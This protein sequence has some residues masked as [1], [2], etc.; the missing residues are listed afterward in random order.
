VLRVFTSLFLRRLFFGTQTSFAPTLERPKFNRGQAS[1]R[2]AA[3]QLKFQR[4]MLLENLSE[5]SKTPTPQEQPTMRTRILTEPGTIFE[6]CSRSPISRQRCACRR[7]HA[8]S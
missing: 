2:R 8:F 6:D 7:V 1:D 4:S 5:G 3:H